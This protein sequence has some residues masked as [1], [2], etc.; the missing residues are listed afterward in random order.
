MDSTDTYYSDC[1]GEQ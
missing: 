1:L